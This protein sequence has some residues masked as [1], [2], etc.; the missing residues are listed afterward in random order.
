MP[1]LVRVTVNYRQH[2]A[3]VFGPRKVFGVNLKVFTR[4]AATLVRHVCS[5]GTG[6]DQYL[7]LGGIGQLSVGANLFLQ[8][9]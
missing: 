8:Q 1:A 2:I 3:T 9:R 4:V 5:R 7:K 6:L